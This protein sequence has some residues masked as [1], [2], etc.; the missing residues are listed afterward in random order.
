[1]PAFVDTNVWVYALTTRDEIRWQQVKALL[2]SLD[3]PSINGQVLR[4]LWRVLLQKSG[5]EE[6]A[7]RQIVVLLMQT[8]RMVPAV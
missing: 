6:A 1:M 7:F 3:S 5:F 4:E 2:C 8:C